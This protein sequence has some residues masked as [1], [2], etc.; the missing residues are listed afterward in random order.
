MKRHA[1]AGLFAFLAAGVSTQGC[2]ADLSFEAK[3]G[4]PCEDCSHC[5]QSVPIDTCVCDTC[6]EF[7]FDH[8]TNELLQCVSSAWEVNRKCPGGGSVAC[9]ESGGYEIRCVDEKGRPWPFPAPSFVAKVGEPCERCDDCKTGD[10]D[11][12]VCRR[13]TELAFD[14]ELN[15]VFDLQWRSRLGG[16]CHVRR[17]WTGRLLLRSRRGLFRPLSRRAGSSDSR[18]DALTMRL[19]QGIRSFWR[20]FFENDQDEVWFEPS[21]S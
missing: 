7:A 5:S 20:Q 4:E 8:E 18:H 19:M 2:E 3:A 1:F 13:C 11:S 17:R 10:D 9:G 12:C 14:E 6:T 16:S 15:Q 21:Q